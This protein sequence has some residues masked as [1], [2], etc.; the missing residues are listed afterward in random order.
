MFRIEIY[1][2]KEIVK[3]GHREHTVIGEELDE[4]TGKMKKVWGWTE[5]VDI[6]EYKDTK[7]FEQRTDKLNLKRVIEAINTGRKRK[8]PAAK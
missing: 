6:S 4:T 1:E 7:I 2:R 5:P 3:K 8:K